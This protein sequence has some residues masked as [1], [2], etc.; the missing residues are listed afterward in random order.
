LLAR[1]A[2]ERAREFRYRF[3]QC[4]IFGAPVLAL[5]WFGPM[6]SPRADEASRWVSLLQAI[7]AGWICYIGALPILVEG[8]IVLRRRTSLDLLVSAA[9]IVAYLYSVV[10]LSGVFIRGRLFYRPL[11]F[12]VVTLVLVLWNGARSAYFRRKALG[13]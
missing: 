5:Q 10:A 1:P 6:L 9:V 13:S 3:A 11:L 8:L 4:L 2:A 7:L 12:F